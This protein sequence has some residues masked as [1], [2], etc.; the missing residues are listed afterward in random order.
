MTLPTP[1]DPPR[2]SMGD[3]RPC[4]ASPSAITARVGWQDGGTR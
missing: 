2:M 4:A 3:E 1:T